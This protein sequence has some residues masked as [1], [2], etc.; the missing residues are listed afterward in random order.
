MENYSKQA[1]LLRVMAHPVRLYILD[2]LQTDSE[3]VCHLSAALGKPQPYI[4]QQLAVLRKA[5][6]VVD[7]R[8]GANS[9]YRLADEAVARQVRAILGSPEALLS[10]GQAERQVVNGCYCPKC[11][12]AGTCSGSVRVET[13]AS[14]AL[15]RG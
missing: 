10:R 5:G 12:P 13:V 7:E 14:A 8:D 1:E 6:L 3:C 2:V 4:S 9:F 11:A 15:A